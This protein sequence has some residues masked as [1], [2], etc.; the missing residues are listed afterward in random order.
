MRNFKQINTNKLNQDIAK[1][2][3]SME[4]T[5]DVNQYTVNFLNV[6]NQ[7]LDVHAPL[8]NV[9]LTNANHKQKLKPWIN[10]DI[11]KLV[12]IKDKIYAKFIKEKN[13]VK[14]Q[15]LFK[16]YKTKKN[17]I[18]KQIR[19]SKKAF[20]DEY[21]TKNSKNLRKLWIGVNQ[22]INKAPNSNSSPT[23]IE[24]K[25]DGNNRSHACSRRIQQTLFNCC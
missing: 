3:W 2:N 23:C 10:K 15:D 12:K 21:F 14:K 19:C 25:E 22:I 11:L 4:T 5:D 24:I 1:I 8:K 7:I 6:F 18:T 17:E 13:S 9:K 20:Y 16:D